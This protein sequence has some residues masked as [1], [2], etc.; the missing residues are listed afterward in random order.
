[1][2][3]TSINRQGQHRG[4]TCVRGCRDGK[5]GGIHFSNDD[6]SVP[7]KRGSWHSQINFPTSIIPI[8]CLSLWS[9]LIKDC[10]KTS[11]QRI[12][13][14]SSCLPRELRGKVFLAK[15]KY[16]QS[17]YTLFNIPPSI[18]FTSPLQCF[19]EHDDA[20]KLNLQIQKTEE[21]KQKKLPFNG[22]KIKQDKMNET[23]ISPLTLSH[24]VSFSTVVHLKK[25]ASTPATMSL[26]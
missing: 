14:V 20:Q 19:Y 26:L 10:S 24:N 23:G 25:P 4:W 15:K 18:D 17:S 1:M 8:P 2:K 7:P 16:T 9:I 12:S 22:K 3:T 5:C 6:S 21:E 11:F 13:S